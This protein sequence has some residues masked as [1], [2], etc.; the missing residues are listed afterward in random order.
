[1]IFSFQFVFENRKTKILI[2]IFN[3]KSK[4]DWREGT[5]IV[6]GKSTTRDCIRGRGS[7]GLALPEVVLF[8]FFSLYLP[9][10]SG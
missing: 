10:F 8:L 2:F 3:W 4:I 5:R 6:Y 7:G 9:L 1:M